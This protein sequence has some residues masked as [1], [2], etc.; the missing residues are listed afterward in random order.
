MRDDRHRRQLRHAAPAGAS[1]AG[2]ATDKTAPTAT[3]SGLKNGQVFSR[4]RAPRSCAA[5]SSADPSGL[6]SV[7]L[8]ILRKV[9]G[10]C[11][12]FDGESERFERHRCGGTCSFRIGDRAEWSYLLPKRLPRGRYTI[13]VVAIDKAGNDSATG[14]EIRVR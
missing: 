6:K 2:A 3:L 5:P 4:K 1:G 11:W 7:R 14:M 9:G 13:R 12:A 8:S 10:R